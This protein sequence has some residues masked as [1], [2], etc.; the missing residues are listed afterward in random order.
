MRKIIFAT[1]SLLFCFTSIVSAQSGSLRAGA[2]KVDITP[3]QSEL[4]TPTD[5][6]RDHLFARAIVMADGRT[7]GALVGF[8]LSKVD[9]T[10]VKNGVARASA[11]TGCPA[12]NFIVSATHNHSSST[13]GMEVGPP[14]PKQQEDAIVEAVNAAKAKLAPARVGYATTKVDLNVNRERFNPKD[15]SW[16]QEANPD[17]PSDK[18][19]AVIEFMGADNIPIGVFMNY[20]MH[21]I[22]FFLTGV[23]SADFPGEASRY[24]ERLFDN[25][26]VAIFSQAPEGDQNPMYGEFA[27]SRVAS[28]QDLIEKLDGTTVYATPM[29]PFGITSSPGGGNSG[30]PPAQGAGGRGTPPAQAAGE[31][32]APASGSQANAPRLGGGRTLPRNPIPP[33]RMEDYKR[34]IEI[35]GANVAMMGTLIGA[36]AMRLMRDVIKPVDNAQIWGARDTAACTTIGPARPDAPRAANRTVPLGLLRI[37]DIYLAAVN[38]EI[39]TE[40]GIHLKAASPA[41]KTVVVA[42]GYGSGGYVRSDNALS[43]LTPQNAGSPQ[44]ACEAGIISKELELIRRSGDKDKQ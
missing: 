26:T 39:Y 31:R 5:I 22:N 3:K 41:T 4:M 28:G 13:F 17:A 2:A 36:N 34:A 43:H 35:T 19:L 30:A 32:G 24:I 1:A 14:L 21:A 8:D 16:Q 6:I 9:E 15:Q 29:R 40:I 18:T 12:D 11:S 23:I 10:A 27:A 44:S 37:G 33:E 38:A 25:R 20:G 42:L 7:C